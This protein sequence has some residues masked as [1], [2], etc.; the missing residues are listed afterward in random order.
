RDV[1]REGLVEQVLFAADLH[2]LD[3]VLGRHLVQ[4]A[5][6]ETRIGE[7]AEPDPGQVPGFAC[8]DIPVEVRHRAERYVVALDLVPGDELVQRGYTGPVPADDP[9]DQA[10]LGQPVGAA[11]LP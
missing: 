8:G 9:L 7:R 11:G 1:D 3:E 4:L 2:E 6:A 10:G 5:A